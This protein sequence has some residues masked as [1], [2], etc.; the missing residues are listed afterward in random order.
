MNYPFRFTY[1]LIHTTNRR[2]GDVTG[3]PFTNMV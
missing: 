2:F 1:K 3:A